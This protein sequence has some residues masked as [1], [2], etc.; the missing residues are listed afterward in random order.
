M[1]RNLSLVF[2]CLVGFGSASAKEIYVDNIIGR[3]TA[4]GMLPFIGDVYGGPVASIH[5]AIEMAEFGDVIV[6]KNNGT[7]YYESISLVGSRNSGSK[8]FPFVIDGGGATL[9]GLRMIPR[10]GWQEVSP[11]IWKLTLTRKGYY[12]LLRNGKPLPE[13]RPE[14]SI[15]AIKSLP[16]GH[17]V[18]WQGSIYFRQDGVLP[19]YQEAFAY[20]ADQTGVSLHSV[21]HV[22]ILNLRLQHYRFDGLHAQGLCRNVVLEGV[23]AIENGRAG[24]ASTGASR[25]EMI[26]GQIA[27]NG[28][29]P[30]L[31]DAFSRAIQQN[32]PAP[33]AA[34]EK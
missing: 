10:A 13:F 19:P 27:G 1:F 29:F 16:P 22:L 20:T 5:R 18:S 3:D 15:N 25:V 7:P 26:G 6:V 24:I 4:D 28:R 14:S 2:V 31:V 32:P 17:W 9:S 8:T 34:V 21:D 23:D 11:R 30:I 33:D 12:Q